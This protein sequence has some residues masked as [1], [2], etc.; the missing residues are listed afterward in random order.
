[1]KL[2]LG[3]TTDTST[4]VHLVH[5]E[6]HHTQ[7]QMEHMEDQTVIPVSSPRPLPRG[8]AEQGDTESTSSL[9]GHW[10]C[11]RALLWPR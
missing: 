2:I 1:M 4:R 11:L 6:A 7:D 10:A 8:L 9:H 5:L 3:R